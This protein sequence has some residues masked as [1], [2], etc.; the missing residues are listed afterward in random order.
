MRVPIP[1]TCN[2]SP[3]LDEIPT[4]VKVAAAAADEDEKDDGPVVAAT[5]DWLRNPVS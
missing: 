3:I 4:D 2:M 5:D 1:V